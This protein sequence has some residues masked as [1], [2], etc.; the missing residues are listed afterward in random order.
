[1]RLVS[2]VLDPFTRNVH[3]RKD[4]GGRKE[5]CGCQEPGAGVGGAGDWGVLGDC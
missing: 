4:L 3:N 5:S 1:M 2:S